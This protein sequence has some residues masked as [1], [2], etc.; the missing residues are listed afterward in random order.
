MNLDDVLNNIENMKNTTILKQHPFKIW[1][2]NSDNRWHTYLPDENRPNK[3]KHIAKVNKTNLEKS[4]IDY[5][6]ALDY[7]K[8]RANLTLRKLYPEW[9]KE[10]SFDTGNSNYMQHIDYEWRTNYKNDS[11]IDIPILKSTRPMLKTW[12]RKKIITHKMTKKQYYNMQIIIRQSLDYLVERNEIDTNPFRG[13]TINKSLFE[14]YIQKDN[15]LEVFSIDEEKAVKDLA[16]KDFRANPHRTS[17]LAIALNFSLGL[18]VGELVALK[19]KDLKSPYLH[20]QQMEQRICIHNAAGN[21]TQHFEVV[22]RTKSD[23]GFRTL[24]VVENALTYFDMIK[25]S[26]LANGYK[27]EANDFIFMYEQKRISS[28]SIDWY[29]EKYCRNLGI[30]KKGN[31]KVRKTCLT[32]IADNPNINLKDAMNFA[33]HSDV[34]TFI[35]NYC[36]SRYSD[37]Y[38]KQEL[39]KSLGNF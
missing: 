8:S 5:Y 15:D 38:K 16:L 36:F 37:D 25:E 29:Y 31:H 26:N 14:P 13:F 17:Y 23:A 30:T 39:E 22:S 2:S 20:I 12:A 32:K 19:W 27:C 28:N 34:K 11:I 24:Y 10:K 33:G 6:L 18:R 4:I 1:L 7:E 9:F 3:R 21:W 35:K